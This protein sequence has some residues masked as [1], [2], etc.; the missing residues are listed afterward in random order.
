MP[1]QLWLP[2]LLQNKDPRNLHTMYMFETHSRSARSS[3]KVLHEETVADFNSRLLMIIMT[4]LFHVCTSFGK[5]NPQSQ[6]LSPYNHQCWSH[7]N[8]GHIIISQDVDISWLEMEYSA[9]HKQDL[10]SCDIGLRLLF[11]IYWIFHFKPTEI[12]FL[13]EYDMAMR[14]VASTLDVL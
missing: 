11:I 10:P 8:H 5:S 4:C 7:C 1:L 9:R 6:F 3:L 13:W 12:D 2:H 14:A